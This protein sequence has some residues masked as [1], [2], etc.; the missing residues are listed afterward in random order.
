MSRINFI[1]IPFKTEAHGGFS[2]T[3]G[4]AKFSSAGIVL[5]FETK[6]LG[7]VNTGVKEAQLRFDEIQSIK[8]KRGLFK[9]GAKIEIRMNTFL[10]LSEFP[11]KDGKIIL[12]IPRDQHAEAADVVE[13]MHKNLQQYNESLPPPQ[14]PVGSLFAPDEFD[15]SEL[16]DRKTNEL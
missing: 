2:Q 7:I 3:D 14:T 6:I 16:D 9:L 12:K 1:S 5:E 15:T 4:L 8:F 13:K 11:N 10:K